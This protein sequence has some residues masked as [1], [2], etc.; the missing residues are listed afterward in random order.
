MSVL[1]DSIEAL[2]AEVRHWAEKVGGKGPGATIGAEEMAGFLFDIA[3]RLEGL[4]PGNGAKLREAVE[5]ICNAITIDGNMAS[6]SLSLFDFRSIAEAALKE[7]ARNCDRHATADEAEKVFDRLCNGRGLHCG[8]H[9]WYYEEAGDC[10]FAWAWDTEP[11][12]WS[13]RPTTAHNGRDGAEASQHPRT[14]EEGHR[15][16]TEGENTGGTEGERK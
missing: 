8:P 10:R 5:K 6:T 1:P 16:Q 14:A 2:A 9:C 13:N 7:P 15:G 4:K 12:D 3:A 11:H